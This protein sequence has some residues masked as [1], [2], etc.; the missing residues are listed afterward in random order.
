[1][2]DKETSWLALPAHIGQNKDS[3][4]ND[5]KTVFSA[6]GTVRPRNELPQIKTKQNK[7]KQKQKTKKK[8]KQ[9]KNSI[10]Y[11]GFHP[12]CSLSCMPHSDD[13]CH[14]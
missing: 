1:M 8:Y 9:T 14:E 3:G 5:R 11:C 12:A 4:A 2:V 6:N 13:P 7:M 10:V